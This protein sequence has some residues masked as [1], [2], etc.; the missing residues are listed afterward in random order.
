MG[1]LHLKMCIP[2]IIWPPTEGSPLN[3]IRKSS[4]WNCWLLDPAQHLQRRKKIPCWLE[5]HTFP[6]VPEF[7][8][9]LR[10]H[11]ICRSMP[12]SLLGLWPHST[13]REKEGTVPLC[14][15]PGLT[16]CFLSFL[17]LLTVR[18]SQIT[19]LKRGQKTKVFETCI[20][21]HVEV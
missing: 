5:W 13:W 16:S 10:P 3:N 12:G 4:L 9:S 11:G 15:P 18:I 6:I 14:I 7:P 2:G 19:E 20:L 21:P 8:L 17:K 1:P